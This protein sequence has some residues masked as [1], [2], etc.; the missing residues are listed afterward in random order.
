[1][2]IV[3]NKCYGG[4]SLSVLGIIEYCKRKGLDKPTFTK[5]PDKILTAE[6]ALKDNDY[7][8]YCNDVEGRKIQRND[9]DLVAVVE[10]LGEKANGQCAELAIVEIPDDIEWDIEEYDGVEWVAEKHRTWD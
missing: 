3:I 10:T 1:M 5:F 7:F 4:F 9:P 8:M 6:E 2:E